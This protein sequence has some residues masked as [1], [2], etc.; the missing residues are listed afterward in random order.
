MV[1]VVLEW[2]VVGILDLRIWWDGKSCQ[3]TTVYT[4]KRI[5][6]ED[7]ETEPQVSEIT[8]RTHQM[9][10][11]VFSVTRLNDNGAPGSSGERSQRRSAISLKNYFTVRPNSQFVNLGM[12]CWTQIIGLDWIWS[13]NIIQSLIMQ[14][15][16]LLWRI[17]EW[18]WTSGIGFLSKINPHEIEPIQ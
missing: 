4:K 16:G 10:T 1:L 5:F 6:R 8:H 7:P 12:S 13:T 14:L 15:V 3:T 17:P 9:Q 18:G 2:D 11:K